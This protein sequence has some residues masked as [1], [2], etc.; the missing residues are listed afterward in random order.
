MNKYE[1]Y[2]DKGHVKASIRNMLKKEVESMTQE[3]LDPE[4]FM[5]NVNGGYS[6][7]LG[8]DTVSGQPIW[9]HITIKVNTLHPSI[10]EY[11]KG[12]KQQFSIPN[13]FD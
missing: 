8:T 5:P 3:N 12:P 11:T 6:I 1:F 4:C 13:L 2:N 7:L 10:D 9:G